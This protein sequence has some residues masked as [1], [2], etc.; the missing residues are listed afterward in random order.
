MVVNSEA[1]AVV[2]AW[3]VYEVRLVCKIRWRYLKFNALWVILR[4]KY[5]DWQTDW[6]SA[7]LSP[8]CSPWAYIMSRLCVLRQW[9]ARK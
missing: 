7:T 8:R 3:E 5:T 4:K 6:T 1:P 9:T 2:H